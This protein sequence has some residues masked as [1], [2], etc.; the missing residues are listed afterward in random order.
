MCIDARV[1]CV[2]VCVSACVKIL[3]VLKAPVY[4]LWGGIWSVVVISLKVIG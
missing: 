2:C 3:E 4:S 1:K